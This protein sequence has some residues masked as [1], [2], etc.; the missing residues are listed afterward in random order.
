VVLSEMAYYLNADLLG[1]VLRRES[2]RWA[3]GA[4][5][6]AAHWRHEV[7]DYP[8]SGDEANDVIAATPGLTRSAV[9]AIPTS[10]STCSTPRVGSRWPPA[11]V[12]R[13]QPDRQSLRRTV[14][15]CR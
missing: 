12:C 10:S 4:T 7:D 3:P 13:A 9:T 11:R 14:I 2:E 8:I 1:E 6:V 5:V 15:P